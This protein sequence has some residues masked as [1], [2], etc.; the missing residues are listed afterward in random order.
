MKTKTLQRQFRLW[1]V[2]LVVVPSVLIMAIY[3]IGQISIAKQQNLE[4]IDQRVHSQERLIDYWMRERAENVR[5]LSQAEAFRTLD[6]QQM[7]RTLILK[8]KLDSSFDSLS[9]VDKNGYFKMSTFHL[10]IQYPSANGKPYFEEAQAGKEYISDVVIGRNSGQSIINFSSPIYDYAGNFQGLILGSVKTVML[11][12][13]LRENWIGQTGE[14]FLVNREGTMLT[15]PRHVNVLIGK[16]LVEDTAKM[17]FKIPDDALSNVRMGK[18]ATAVWTDY[19]GN[20]VLGACLNVPERGWTIIGKINEGEVLAPIYRQLAM[21][22][23]GTIILILFILPLAKLLTNRI[24]LPIDWLI[25]QS[26]QLATENYE[27][28]GLDKCSENIPYELSTLCDTFVKMSHK[29]G[30]TVGLLKE[31]EVK[32]ENK[33]LEIQEINATL[34]EEMME[35]QAAQAALRKLNADLENNINERTRDLQDMNAALEEE[36]MERQ[37][38][39]EAL[40]QKAEVIRQLAYSDS[41]THL[42][43]RA[44]IN[45]RLQVEMEKTRRGESAGAVLFI[46]LDDLKMVNDTFG[47]TYGDAL[48]NMAGN[49]I[50]EAAG[51][52]V[53]VGRVGGDEFMV[54]LPGEYNRTNITDSADRIIEAFSQDMEVLGIRF[55]TS[56][57]AGIA[58]YPVDGDTTEEIFKNADNAM[59][60]AKKAGKNCWRFYEAAMQAEAYD[61]ILMINSLRHAVERD[62]LLLHYQPQVGND[63][64][65]VGFEALL[66]WNS[67][68]YGSIPP[69]RFIQLAEQSGLIQSVGNWVLRE[70]CQFARRLADQG[71]GHIRVAVNVSPCQLCANNFIDSVREAIGSAGIEPRQ[72]EIEIT[73]NALIESLEES[74]HILDK[75]QLMGVRLSL[76][77]FGTGYSSLTYLQRL[78]VRTLKIDKAFIDMIQTAGTQKAII[79]TIVDIAHIME[80]T[81]VAEGVETEAQIDYLVRCRCDLL[82]GYIISPPISE[83]EAVRFLLRQK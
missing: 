15:E 26:N 63:G 56:A 81:V 73:E 44:H 10:E 40:S 23:G 62:E 12:T 77:D 71:W 72:L 68:E 48:I 18:S 43:N 69:A 47:H 34:E 8:Q 60:A 30:K 45:E 6:E 82:Q 29:I 59:Y 42:P 78:P 64:V 3:T 58:L 80:M 7:K 74:T 79:G 28:I 39:Q 66:R 76:D 13:L 17:K 61:K 27:M 55:H 20:K 9:Y 67:S 32:L 52:G 46:D 35:R 65:T 53:F 41:L 57:S 75:I 22:A 4:L 24:K 11:E 16:G 38:A 51:N 33:M 2:L 36:I 50:V 54:V 83:E 21:M 70:S 14:V 37:T 25:G 1:T 5:E 19:L 31:N 49:R